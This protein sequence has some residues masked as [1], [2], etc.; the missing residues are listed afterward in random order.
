MI[1]GSL[2]CCIVSRRNW[3]S[4]QELPVDNVE[5]TQCCIDLRE[6]E[7]ESNETIHFISFLL[8]VIFSSLFV[9]VWLSFFLSSF[10]RVHFLP[11][12]STRVCSLLIWIILQIKIH[13]INVYRF[14]FILLLVLT[15]KSQVKLSEFKKIVWWYTG[16]CK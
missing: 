12:S 1:A 2:N 14:V 11:K 3:C 10:C 16:R 6:R 7:R 15:R 8:L 5:T 13:S 9:F 4:L